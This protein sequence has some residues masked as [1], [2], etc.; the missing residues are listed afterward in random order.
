MDLLAYFDIHRVLKEF[1]KPNL[2]AGQIE[3]YADR[4][5]NLLSN[6]LNFAQDSREIFLVAMGGVDAK[7]INS[8]ND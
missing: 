3:E 4:E 1:T 8:V 5:A 6:A 7:D 2:G